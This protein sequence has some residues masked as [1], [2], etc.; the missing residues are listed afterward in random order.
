VTITAVSYQ[1]G[2]AGILEYLDA[3][4]A[5][6]DVLLEFDQL[7]EEL[8]LARLELEASVGTSLASVGIP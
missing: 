4:R 7:S 6:R 1:Q 5:Q 3:L 8:Q 2:E